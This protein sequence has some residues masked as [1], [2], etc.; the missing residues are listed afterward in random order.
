VKALPTPASSYRSGRDRLLEL[1]DVFSV[2][3]LSRVMNIAKPAALVYLSRW[4]QRRW[5]APAGPRTGIYFNLVR[6]PK[7]E[8]EL[9][10]EALRMRYPS[11]TLCGASVL[12]AAGWTTQI[13]ANMHVAIEARR[14]YAQFTEFELHPRP[15]EW[16]R[17]A[18]ADHAL[19]AAT[20]ASF[21]SYGLRTLS[22]AWALAD[23]ME[24]KGA[25]HPDPDDLDI[26]ARD[27]RAVESARLAIRTLRSRAPI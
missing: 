17:V 26:S 4:S 18:Q 3:V 27:E 24:T 5:V 6:L 22:P 13:P 2:A 20:A 9:R 25:W 14:T 7:A 16:F 11:A 8:S 10:T 1:P 19:L 21:S 12:H 15:L 23:L